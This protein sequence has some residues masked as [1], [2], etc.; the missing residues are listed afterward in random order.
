MGWIRKTVLCN[1][2]YCLEIK[3]LEIIVVHNVVIWYAFHTNIHTRAHTYTHTTH[4][5]TRTHHTH[6]HIHTTHTTQTTH[7]HHTPHTTHTNTHTH[8]HHTYTQH[9]HP[10]HTQT[11]SAENL[12]PIPPIL[13]TLSKILWLLKHGRCLHG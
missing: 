3:A 2:V 12:S 7:T 8:T 5:H 6:T 11:P 1:H 9:T 13:N 4:T 10:T